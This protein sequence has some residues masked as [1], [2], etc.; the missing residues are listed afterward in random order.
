MQQ[1]T[2]ALIEEFL[3]KGGSISIDSKTV[4][5]RERP[6]KTKPWA[7]EYKSYFGK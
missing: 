3:N 5:Y 7:N 2:N 1:N 6:K 4:Q